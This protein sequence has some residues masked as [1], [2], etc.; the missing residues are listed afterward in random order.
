SST[1]ISVSRES[2]VMRRRKTRLAIY[3]DTVGGFGG[4]EY[5]V[6]VLA[7]AA[8]RDREVCLEHHWQG[9]T[10]ET[11]SRFVG[12]DLSAVTLVTVPP[13]C[14]PVNPFVEGA[15]AYGRG[16]WR[17]PFVSDRV[18]SEGFEQFISIGHGPPPFNRAKAGAHYTHFPLFRPFET[19]PFASGGT[20]M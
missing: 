7:A 10:Q 18:Y 6:G 1:W 14:A 15:W 12:S 9:V 13:A 8:S 2:V 17:A 11:W 20:G 5:C 16:R 4:N 19:C 3:C